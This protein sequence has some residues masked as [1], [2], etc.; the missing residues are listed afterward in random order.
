M[1]PRR[2]RETTWV[3]MK[4]ARSLWGVLLAAAAS[5][6][7][8]ETPPACERARADG[9]AYVVCTFDP[10]KDDIRVFHAGA[11]GAPYGSFSNLTRALAE[12][13][14]TLRF[15]MNAG[16]YDKARN[17][18]GLYV[19]AGVVK[20]SANTNEGPGNFHLMPNGVFWVT[21]DGE[22]RVATTEAYLSGA[23]GDAIAFATQSG[24]MLVIDGAL[25]PKFLPA[26]TSRKIRNGVGVTKAGDVVFVKSDTLVTFH[27]FARYFK[28]ALGADN[29]LFLDGTISRVYAPDLN[30]NDG[31][32]AMGPI[33]GVVSPA[34][35]AGG[36]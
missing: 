17:P 25:H 23:A 14:Q 11:D 22:A 8:A 28:N 34:Q 31:G 24:P 7:C 16:M 20:K 21:R 27:A 12:N 30:R 36:R 19:E 5:A 4:L 33:V 9:A 3:R 35:D 15:A 18:I 29:A 1:T 6:A 26:S 10:Q 2:R 32:A 13:D